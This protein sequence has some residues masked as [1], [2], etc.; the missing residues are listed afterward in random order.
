MTEKNLETKEAKKAALKNLS[1]QDFRNFGLHQIA[2]IRP[3]YQDGDKKYAI[4]GADGAYIAAESDLQKA[5]VTARH[6]D[7]EPV[8]LH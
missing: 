3:L 2:Y 7:L 5:I 1:V 6:K 4:H 8:T